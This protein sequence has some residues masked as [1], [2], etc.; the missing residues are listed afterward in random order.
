MGSSTY[1]PRQET[2]KPKQHAVN[3]RNQHRWDQPV[4]A[5][6]PTSKR[7]CWRVLMGYGALERQFVSPGRTVPN[8]RIL[9]PHRRR[10]L[11][12]RRRNPLHRARPEVVQRGAPG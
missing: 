12:N 3:D 10:A 1:H 6:T 5:A 9:G 4:E 11:A 2:T 8:L 7:T